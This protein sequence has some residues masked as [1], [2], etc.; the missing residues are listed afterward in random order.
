MGYLDTGNSDGGTGG[1]S[2]EELDRLREV[3]VYILV[4]DTD[5]DMDDIYSLVFKDGDNIIWH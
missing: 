2:S 4:E 3:L 1:L 5:L